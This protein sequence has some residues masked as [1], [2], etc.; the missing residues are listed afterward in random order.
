VTEHAQLL[1]AGNVGRVSKD[2]SGEARSV[3]EQQ[4]ANR[5][6]AAVLGAV[7]TAE[8][9][10]VQS[11]SRFAA[12]AREDWPRLLADVAAAR[13]DLVLLWETSRGSRVLSE[14]VAFV[15]L[16]RDSGVLVHIT[17]HG[18]TYDPRARRDRKM[19]L[20]DG[21]DNEDESEKTS[22]RVRRALAANAEN[23]QPHS[24]P[25]YGYR[26]RYDPVTGKRDRQ[27]AQDIVEEEATVVR[28][29]IAAVAEETP[30]SAIERETGIQRSTI[31]KWCLNPAYIGKRRTPG[32]MV[33]ARW[34]AI[35]DEETWH[36]AR[37]V[38]AAK[39][40]AGAGSRPGAVKYLLSSLAGCG[41]CPNLLEPDAANARRGAAYS[42]RAGHVSMSMAAVDE[43]IT[44]LVVARCAEPDLYELLTAASGTEAETARAEAG[45]LQAEL[46]EWLE[47]DI[48]P[49]AYKAK[50]DKLL[51]LIAAARERADLLAIP[52]PV[53][54]LVTAR[55]DVAAAWLRLSVAQRRGAV[56][57]LFAWIKLD[58]APSRRGPR[59]PAKDR[60]RWEWKAFNRAGNSRESG[61][62]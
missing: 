54:D 53:R 22:E 20:E 16:C 47:A 50:E 39:P 8:Y 44:A 1:R 12:K 5:A 49:R 40:G 24:Q 62:A 7:I 55:D 58:P 46:D 29:V 61:T 11:A 15:D 32:G 27:Q 35:V 23:G 14:W 25:P 51:P 3:A 9:E 28:K 17:S 43:V 48:S 42:C 56:R 19:L 30:L 33:D 6:A 41:T 34:P 13:L 31:R 18:R 57:F 38:L 36:Q 59:V 60:L 26:R 21:I 4:E 37:A 45:R 2:K 10:D 52:A